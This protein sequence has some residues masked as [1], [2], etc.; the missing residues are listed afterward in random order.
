MGDHQ[1]NR[2]MDYRRMLF[3]VLIAGP[4][5]ALVDQAKAA[6]PTAD[7]AARRCADAECVGRNQ[8]RPSARPT[9]EERSGLSWLP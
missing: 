8:Q 1:E 6:E 3:V 2:T 4:V 7:K 5:L 9:P